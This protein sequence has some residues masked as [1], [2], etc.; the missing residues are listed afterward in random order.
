MPEYVFGL[1]S[2]KIRQFELRA[3]D[4]TRVVS[5]ICIPRS[6]AITCMA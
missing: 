2:R 1:V 3:R 5:L 4:S 6:E